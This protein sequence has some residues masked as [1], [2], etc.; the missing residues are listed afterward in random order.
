MIRIPSVDL[1][2]VTKGVV[3]GGAVGEST[4]HANAGARGRDD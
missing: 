2:G 4:Q 3:E 1:A